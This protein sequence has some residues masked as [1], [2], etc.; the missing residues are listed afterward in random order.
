[1]SSR[2]SI[3]RTNATPAPPQRPDRP[4][5]REAALTHLSRFA[6]TERA[7]SQVLERRILRW[8][9]RAT[10]AGLDAGEVSAAVT[11]LRPLAEQI[12]CEM[13]ALGA[14]NDAAFAKARA[15]RLTRSGRSRRA[16]Q[17]RLA[18][19]GL[20][21]SVIDDALENALG[22]GD[23]GRDAE[24]AAAL[25]FARK[26]RIGPFSPDGEGDDENEDSPRILAA[27]ARAG[28]S[29]DVAERALTTERDEADERI[30]ALRNSA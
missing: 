27:F 16:V 26:R 13:T 6:T 28:F 12:A 4:G 29:R 21:T 20:D 15:A 7:L 23:A 30:H 22:E 1:M 5:L 3:S 8:A 25:V 11:E 18:A 17:T 2:R 10:D 9:Q 19:K 14:V 24:L